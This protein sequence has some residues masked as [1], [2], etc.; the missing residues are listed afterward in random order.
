MAKTRVTDTLVFRDIYNPLYENEYEGRIKMKNKFKSVVDGA[1]TLC[2]IFGKIALEAYDE[3]KIQE[4]IDE[5]RNRDGEIL[6]DEELIH[7]LAKRVYLAES[8]NKN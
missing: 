8:E 5:E 3:C 6:S 1:A 7:Q 2:V 4:I